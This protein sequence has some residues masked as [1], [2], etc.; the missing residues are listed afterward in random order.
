M[1]ETVKYAPAAFGDFRFFFTGDFNVKSSWTYLLKASLNACYNKEFFVG[2]EVEH[3]TTALKH[4]TATL[5]WK[6]KDHM[7]YAKR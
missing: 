2:G 6:D 3:D 4:A 5:A 1:T 7:L